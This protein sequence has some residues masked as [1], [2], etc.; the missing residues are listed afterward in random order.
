MAGNACITR[1]FWTHTHSP[2]RLFCITDPVAEREGFLSC[3]HATRFVCVLVLH[4]LLLS[5]ALGRDFSVVV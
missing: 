2:P 1:N 5:A 3:L 4:V